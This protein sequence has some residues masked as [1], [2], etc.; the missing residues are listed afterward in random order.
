MCYYL[1]LCNTKECFGINDI[2]DEDLQ[3]DIYHLKKIVT[4]RMNQT[5][6]ESEIF[7]EHEKGVPGFF[8]QEITGL[9]IL[10]LLTDVV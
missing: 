2:F 6:S 4:F 8:I 5:Q 9:R 3:Q 1:T 10:V 7:D